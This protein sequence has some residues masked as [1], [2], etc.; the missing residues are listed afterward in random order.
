[1]QDPRVSHAELF[2]D[3]D[4]NFT[5]EADDP[6]SEESFDYSDKAKGRVYRDEGKRWGV[7]VRVRTK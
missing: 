2:L 5:D 6:D 4:S 3:G 1:M 7:C